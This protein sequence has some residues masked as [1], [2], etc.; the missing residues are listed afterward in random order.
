MTLQRW[1]VLITAALL[2]LLFGL[3]AAQYPGFGSVRVALN[4]FTDNA[5]LAIAAFGMTFV[6][7]SGGIDLSVGAVVA[8]SGVLAAVLIEQAGWPPVAAFVL[9]LALGAAFGAAMGA[10]IDVYRLQPFIV[11]LAGMFVARGIA[12]VLSEQSVPIDHDLYRSVNAFGVPLGSGWLGSAALA[13]ALVLAATVWV[14]NYT[15]LGAYIYAIGGNAESA[16][17]MGVPV[18]KTTIA[19]YALSSSLAALAGVV[20]SFYTASGYALAGIGLELDAIAAVVIGGTLL[21]G[22]YGTLV[23]TLLGVLLMGLIQTYISFNGQLNSWWTKIVV[24]ALVLLFVT[25]QR[26]GLAADRRDGA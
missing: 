8:L 14:A 7:V 18:R 21:A 3:G 19:I 17:L 25:L 6:V 16:R 22:G 23:G 2:V 26:I 5:F 1:P 10:L 9:I 24:G 11:T 20:Y 15:R 13:L 12:L 4:L